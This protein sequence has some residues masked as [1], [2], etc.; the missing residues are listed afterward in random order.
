MYIIG[1]LRL[2]GSN[3]TSVRDF[4]EPEDVN[5]AEYG[6][7]MPDTAEATT[8]TGNNN[9]IVPPVD[10]NLSEACLTELRDCENHWS[11]ADTNHH[12]PKYLEFKRIV[13]RHVTL[14]N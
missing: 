9:V 4:F 5:E 3:Y 6:V 2:F 14:T 13:N 11:T 10:T 7:D 12:I 1:M 8:H